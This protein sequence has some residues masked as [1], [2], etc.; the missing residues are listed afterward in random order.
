L[1]YS[2]LDGFVK[3]PDAALRFI[4]PF[5]K[6]RTGFAKSNAGKARVV[7][8]AHHERKIASPELVEGL[9]NLACFSTFYEFII[10]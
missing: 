5:G 4:P 2:F 3:S 7:R 9:S 1:A 10:P 6:L 8:Q